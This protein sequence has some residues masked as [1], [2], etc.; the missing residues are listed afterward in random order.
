M[1]IKFLLGHSSIQTSGRYL[2]SERDIGIVVNDN[3]GLV[4]MREKDGHRPTY[5]A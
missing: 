3:V 1:Q 4:V 5:A 2:G